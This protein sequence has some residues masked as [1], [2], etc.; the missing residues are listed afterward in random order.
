[1]DLIAADDVIRAIELY[2]RGGA[3]RYLDGRRDDRGGRAGAAL[4]PLRTAFLTVTDDRFFVG[5]LATVNSILHYHPDAEILV[6]N[7]TDAGLNDHQRH[8]LERA[9]VR[10][11]DSDLF[12]AE[13]RHIGPWELKAYAARDL[14]PRYDLL[15]GID[16]DCVLCAGVGDVAHRTLETG[17]FT[18]GQDGGG[19]TYDE[20]YAP[21]GIPPG[22]SNPHYLSTSLYFCPTTPANREI[23]DRWA[24]L[25]ERGG[26]QPPRALSR[27]RRP[28]RPEQRDLRPARG[29]TARTCSRTRRGASTGRTGTASWSMTAIGSS[30]APDRIGGSAA[31]TAAG[32]RSSGRSRTAT[33]S[34]RPTPRSR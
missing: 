28:G 19:V 11:F 6:V 12:R 21:Y 20:S 32:S 8:L 27:L 1:M 29:R 5:T 24:R 31:C 4:S 25:H 13:G 7:R 3:Y 22:A 33:A 2:H 34:S 10:I 9:N 18:G 16:S 30:T 23:L 17:L 26:V 15:I 14:A